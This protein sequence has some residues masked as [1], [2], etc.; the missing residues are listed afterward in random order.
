M[1]KTNLP[2][3]NLKTTLLGGQAFNFDFIPVD[4]DEN[5]FWGFTQDRVIKLK[6]NDDTLYWQTYP[7]NDDIDF[8]KRY[9]RLDVDYKD[10]LKKIQKDYYIKSAIKK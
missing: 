3:Y 5:C 6:K 1:N 4:K 10:I 7:E 8:L 9:L 2:N